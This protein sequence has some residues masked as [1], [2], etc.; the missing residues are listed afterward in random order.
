MGCRRVGF[1]WPALV[2]WALAAL[3]AS[4][5]TPRPERRPTSDKPSA[6]GDGSTPVSVFAAVRVPL[7]QVPE[8]VRDKVR[9]VVEQPTFATRGPAEAFNCCPS[10]YFWLL[11]HPDL[12]VRLWRRMGAKCTDIQARG[13]SSFSWNDGQGN[14]MR[15]DAV[16]NS[17]E[18]RI[19]YAE[20]HVRPGLLLPAV[21][22]RAVVVLN[23][24]EG[25]DARGRPAIRHQVGLVLHTDSRTANLAAH[26]LGASAPRMAEQYVSQI[27]MFFGALAWY[28]DQHPDQAE[29]LFSDLQRPPLKK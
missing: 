21:P 9:S 10:V 14:E 7:D 28:L 26:L 1:G 13:G 19:W 23:H 16:V 22:V 18:Q 29:T 20:G 27:Q 15:W 2:V 8:K 24:A 3:P 11:D 4:A 6:N 12:A 17:A 5:Q 25:Q